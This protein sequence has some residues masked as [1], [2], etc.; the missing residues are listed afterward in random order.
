M[1]ICPQGRE[2]AI[3]LEDGKQALKALRQK[4]MAEGY[5][6]VNITLLHGQ[7]GR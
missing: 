4:S 6:C 3:V 2:K 5:E 7:D 1:S